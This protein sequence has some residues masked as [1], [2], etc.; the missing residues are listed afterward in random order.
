MLKRVVV[1]VDG[2]DASWEALAYAARIVEHGGSLALVDVKDL[3]SFFQATAGVSYNMSIG[4]DVSEYVKEWDTDAELVKKKALEQTKDFDG[5]VEW[6]V[7]ESTDGKGGPAEALDSFARNWNAE[8]IVVGRHHGSTL[9]E[10]MFGSFPRWLAT[11]SHFPTTV[12]PV[13]KKD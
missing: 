11:H 3:M 8:A 12:V 13:S 5:Q 4:V 9:M 1:A 6:H 7:V 10:G 2:S